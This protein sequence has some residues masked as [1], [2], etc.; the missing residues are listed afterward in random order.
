MAYSSIDF[1]KSKAVSYAALKFSKISL[2]LPICQLKPNWV[3]VTW[4]LKGPAPYIRASPTVL[5]SF[6]SVGYFS[7]TLASSM[8]SVQSV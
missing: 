5:A 1:L 8:T 7:L 3:A 4:I 2:H 6:L